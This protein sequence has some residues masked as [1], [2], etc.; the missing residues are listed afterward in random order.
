M[1]ANTSR[2]LQQPIIKSILAKVTAE[3]G[4]RGR[5][6]TCS[7][8]FS[9]DFCLSSVYNP[10]TRFW[11]E[12]AAS[13]LPC[14]TLCLPGYVRWQ[15][16]VHVSVSGCQCWDCLV[17]CPGHAP[18]LTT[19]RL[20]L[21]LFCS[22]MHDFTRDIHLFAHFF[23]FYFVS[24]DK[25]VPFYKCTIGITDADLFYKLAKVDVRLK[26]KQKWTESDIVT[27]QHKRLCLCEIVVDY[28]W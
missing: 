3:S 1:T 14:S 28:C 23:L 10:E 6:C 16:D 21:A 22:Q 12:P 5:S 26:T 24:Y 18:T 15:I 25:N 27:T 7:C 8:C 13:V 19:C 11:M 2:L 9:V 4:F 20:G 17:S